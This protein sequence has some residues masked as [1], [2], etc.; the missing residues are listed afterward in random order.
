MRLIC[1]LSVFVLTFNVTVYGQTSQ[2]ANPD[3]A[4]FVNKD[5]R[6]SAVF[7]QNKQL[8]NDFNRQEVTYFTHHDNINAFFTGSSVIYRI[9]QVDEK[10]MVQRQIEEKE[11]PAEK[12]KGIAVKATS[13]SMEWV[14]ANPNPVIEP[15]EKEQGYFVYLKNEGS[16]LKS[17]STDGYKTITYKELYPGVDV[18]YS[19]PEKGGMEYN[20]LVAPGADLSKVKMAW[21]ANS[22]LKKDEEGNLIVHTSCG[23]IIE[24]APVSFSTG[25]VVPSGFN[26]TGNIVQFKFPT[27]YNSNATLI[28]DPWVTAITTMPTAN[29]GLGVDYDFAGDLFVYGVGQVDIYDM[30]TFGHI[31]KYSPAGVVQWTFNGQIANP[32]WTTGDV[33]DN[34][35]YP[36]GMIVDKL[37][38]KV[39]TGQGY[40]ATGATVVRLD[41]SGQYDH[42]ISD[43]DADFQET[44]GF[45]YRC[46]DASVVAL[47][48]GTTSNINMAK[49]NTT[50]AAVATSN[51]TGISSS[52][53]NFQDIVCGTYDT[54]GNLYVMMNDGLGVLPYTN[55]IYKVNSTFTGN[56]WAAN[57]NHTCFGELRNCPFWSVTTG[58]INSNWYNCLSA[59]GSYLFYCDGSTVAAYSLDS[60]KVVGTP[61]SIIGYDTLM[62]GGVAVDYCNHVYVGGVGVIKTFTFNGTNFLQGADIL[63]GAG[64]ASDTIYDV[65]YYAANNLLY[66]TGSGFAGTYVA[67]LGAGCNS[68]SACE[69]T[70][71]T[72]ISNLTK[73]SL[74][75]YPNPVSK[76]LNLVSDINGPYT[77]SVFDMKGALM[78]FKSFEGVNANLDVSA[79]ANGVYMV[80]INSSEG[81][82]R[83]KIVKMD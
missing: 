16:S 10:E 13:F 79:L 64:F 38:G 5:L 44:W 71:F 55:T 80:M 40:Y 6:R 46:P 30:T 73:Q 48:G 45:V 7:L 78:V 60:G 57:S 27:G 53:A 43:V 15:G 23:D 75:L 19:F 50:T 26:I 17:V 67:S 81:T 51:I 59:N 61:Y 28:I 72:D 77:V 58:G 49:I 74:I 32:S 66:V 11:T 29:V 39:Y 62:Q 1:C 54:S 70:I 34:V 22:E 68:L 83:E 69:P 52:G 41:T 76:V 12:E 2:I 37:S 8:V 82:L 35:N 24:H 33:S 3:K 9:N 21:S 36:S 42:F 14:G 31:S 18:V 65:K 56:I 63:L 47:G 4:T 25:K 20:L